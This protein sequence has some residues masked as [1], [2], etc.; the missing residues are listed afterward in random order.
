MK[1]VTGKG[2]A[3]AYPR[4]FFCSLGKLSTRVTL[5]TARLNQHVYMCNVFYVPY[6]SRRQFGSVPGC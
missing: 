4:G 1:I 2:H 5:L 6:K 3:D